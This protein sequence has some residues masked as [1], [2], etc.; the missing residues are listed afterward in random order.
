MKKQTLEEILN[1]S[2]TKIMEYFH[3]FNQGAK[4]LGEKVQTKC[5]AFMH[6]NLAEFVSWLSV[7]GIEWKEN[8]TAIL[9]VSEKLENAI[10]RFGPKLYQKTQNQIEKWQTSL[11]QKGKLDSADRV[12]DTMHVAAADVVETDL[13][14]AINFS[15]KTKTENKITDVKTFAV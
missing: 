15:S 7:K 3:E 1:S 14:A 12:A 5:R 10:S 9:E 13:G 4:P 2:K 11:I 6:K 8:E